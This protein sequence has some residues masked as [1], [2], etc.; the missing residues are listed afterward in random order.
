MKIA[1]T[2]FL[3]LSLFLGQGRTSWPKINKQQESNVVSHQH[4]QQAGEDP[5]GAQEMCKSVVGQELGG[6]INTAVHLCK[7][8]DRSM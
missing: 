2:S 7:F 1:A 6:S 8:K 4:H 3:L 5:L